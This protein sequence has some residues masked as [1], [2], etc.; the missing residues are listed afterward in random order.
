MQVKEGN[1]VLPVGVLAVKG[2]DVS[3]SVHSF[4]SP[5]GGLYVL[6]YSKEV[7]DI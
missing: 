7:C 2:Y 4:G 3:G 6:L 1:T 5:I